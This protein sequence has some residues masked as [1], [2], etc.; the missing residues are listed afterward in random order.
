[1]WLL[2]RPEIDGNRIGVIGS[3]FGSFF[4]A[5]LMSEEPRYKACAITGTCYE[6]GGY[7]I[8]EEASP[9]FKKRF[10]F[11]SGITDEGEFD[12]FG[13]PLG[14]PGCAGKGRPPYR[15]AAGEAE[16]P[17]P[18]EHREICDRARGAPKRL[19]ISQVSRHSIGGVPSVSNGPEPRTY[20]AE[21]MMARL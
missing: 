10:M 7:T 16:E 1:K 15:V 18:L 19:V 11:M 13:K 4:S 3:S 14:G 5:I 9:T 21:W 2:E 20:Q 8:F 6:P 12:T 17:C